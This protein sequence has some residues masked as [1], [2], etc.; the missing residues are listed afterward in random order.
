ML[1]F[2][3]NV[4]MW[5]SQQQVRHTSSRSLPPLLSRNLSQN[6]LFSVDFGYSWLR[7]S[8]RFKT[9]FKI[10]RHCF[11]HTQYSYNSRKRVV[12]LIYSKLV[13]SLS[14]ATKLC[15]VNR[16]LAFT[17][18]SILVMKRTILMEGYDVT[19]NTAKKL[20]GLPL[21]NVRT[22][23]RKHKLNQPETRRL[24]MHAC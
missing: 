19:N 21:T 12:G 6:T 7:L 24:Y 11:W 9:C 15:R 1:H 5:I 2:S 3:R 16:P 14:H 23:V 22:Y 8:Q 10:L 4:L 20:E 18:K 17:V 13:V